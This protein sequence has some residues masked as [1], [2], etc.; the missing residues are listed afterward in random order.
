MDDCLKHYEETTDVKEEGNNI[1]IH[2]GKE[3]KIS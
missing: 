2:N 1:K 3:Q